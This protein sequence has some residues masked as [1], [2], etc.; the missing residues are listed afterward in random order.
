MRTALGDIL[1][2]AADLDEVFAFG[3][4][5]LLDGLAHLI[6][7]R[8]GWWRVTQPWPDNGSTFGR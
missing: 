4:T 8:L 5:R 6:G 2:A 3:L 1:T 7:D